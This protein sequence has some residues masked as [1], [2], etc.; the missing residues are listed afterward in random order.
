MKS[1]K[2]MTT[3]FAKKNKTVFFNFGRKKQKI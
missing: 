1:P 3:G 2:N